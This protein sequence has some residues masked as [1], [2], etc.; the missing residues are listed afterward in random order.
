MTKIQK[1]KFQNLFSTR[2]N[3]QRI[4]KKWQY[5]TYSG[6]KNSPGEIIKNLTRPSTIT[7]IVGNY[8][9]E[10]V[11]KYVVDVTTIL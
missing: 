9:R 2:K 8:D 11:L 6:K 4:K 10:R 5:I 1:E 3:V 7:L